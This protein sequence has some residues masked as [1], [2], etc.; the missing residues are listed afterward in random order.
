MQRAVA[1]LNGAVHFGPDCRIVEQQAHHDPTVAAHFM[2]DGLN[3]DQASRENW[4]NEAVEGLCEDCHD[5]VHQQQG[6]VKVTQWTVG[7]KFKGPDES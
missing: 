3:M 4:N 2:S 7:P 1:S 6:Q 5:I